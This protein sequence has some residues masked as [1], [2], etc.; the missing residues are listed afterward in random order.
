MWM[1]APTVNCTYSYWKVRWVS[2]CSIQLFSTLLYYRIG[3]LNSMWLPIWFLGDI[4]GIDWS[5]PYYAVLW[6]IFLCIFIVACSHFLNHNPV[7]M[8]TTSQ[9]MSHG[10]TSQLHIKRQ[11]IY[12]LTHYSFKKVKI[13]AIAS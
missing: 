12:V 6:F 4:F 13:L 1:C 10:V 3:I 2:I 9:K 11:H 5:D 7:V 8:V